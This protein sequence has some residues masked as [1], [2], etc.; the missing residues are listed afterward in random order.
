MSILACVDLCHLNRKI[1]DHAKIKDLFE[2]E[3]TAK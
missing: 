3:V 1:K 2:K